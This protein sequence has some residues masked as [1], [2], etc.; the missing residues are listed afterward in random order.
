MFLRYFFFFLLKLCLS[1]KKSDFSD[2]SK[3]V[4]INFNRVQSSRKL[5]FYFHRKNNEI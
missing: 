4:F 2:V 5:E 3:F 1:I